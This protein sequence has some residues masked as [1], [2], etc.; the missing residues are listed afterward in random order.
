[1]IKRFGIIIL[2]TRLEFGYRA[3]LWYTAS[4]PKY[5]YAP[6]FGKNGMNRHRFDILW[7]HVRWSHQTDVRDYSKIHEADQWKLVQDF[8]TNFNEYRIHL[9][10]PSDLIFSD[11]SILRWYRQGG[12]WINLGLLVYVAMERKPENGEEI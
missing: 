9:F 3:S 6:D 8:V 2:S 1:M 10:S 4:Q 5:R 12:H 7:R 11:E